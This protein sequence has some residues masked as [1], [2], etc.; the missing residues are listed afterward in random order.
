MQAVLFLGAC[1][2]LDTCTVLEKYT[3]CRLVSDTECDLQETCDGNS[4]K[5]PPN[6]YKQDGTPCTNKTE[7][8]CY[9][10]KCK[11]HDSQCFH[12][13]GKSTAR[14]SEDTCYKQYNNNSKCYY[15][16]TNCVELITSVGSDSLAY[17]LIMSEFRRR[18]QP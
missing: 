5:C 16:F 8:F 6:T 10:G 14:K 13:W 12:V 3:P 15:Y 2:N 4:P 11:S 1:C 9:R 17:S 7:A 18:K